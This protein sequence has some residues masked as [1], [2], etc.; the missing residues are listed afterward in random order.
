[1]G[2]FLMLAL[3]A[4]LFFGPERLPQIGARL[5]RWLS[6]LTQA[7]KAFMTQWTE[8]AA[9]IQDAVNEVRG[10]RDE[11]RAAQAE[12]SG[13][14][15]VA[16]Q[17]ISETINEARGTVREAAVTPQGILAA[18]TSAGDATVDTSVPPRLATPEE[19]EQATTV[20]ATRSS[21]EGEALSKT[22]DVLDD[23]LAKRGLA[24]PEGEPG[25]NGAESDEASPPA[26]DEYERNLRAIQEIMDRDARRAEEKAAQ[27]A[28][29][30]PEPGTEEPATASTPEPD[31]E[32]APGE[33]QEEVEEQVRES[34]YEKTQRILDGLLGSAVEA[35]PPDTDERPEAEAE[36]APE[37]ETAE[38]STPPQAIPAKGALGEG[39][40]DQEATDAEVPVD[41]IPTVEAADES[42]LE[43]G[44]T[45]PADDAPAGPEQE[46]GEA[47]PSSKDGRASGP[48]SGVSQ[49]EFAEL[50][51][52]VIE[53]G[54]RLET[55]QV[56]LQALRA[57]RSPA[58]DGPEAMSMENAA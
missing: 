5:G 32:P 52:Q 57:A 38:L 8:E 10:I 22:Q 19:T 39:A 21:D 45:A 48:D 49:R 37:L 44:E 6:Q 25:D 4:L 20:A 54:R 23:L 18:G 42:V 53:L 51:E 14:L 24:E 50:S 13:S 16:R 58:D 29:A 56:E 28:T 17:E 55:L 40:V 41:T 12:I 3:F 1:M 11:I 27:R 35:E 26:T 30:A 2:E 34:A 47:V 36:P 31:E 43:E 46:A 15:N 7:S 9:A 33:Q